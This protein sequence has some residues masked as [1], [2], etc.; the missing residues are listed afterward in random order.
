ME[1]VPGTV[2]VGGSAAER[3]WHL[4]LKHALLDHNLQCPL[5]ACSRKEDDAYFFISAMPKIVF[6][7]V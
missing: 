2:P 6:S 7:R 3:R 1:R 4:T 5:S